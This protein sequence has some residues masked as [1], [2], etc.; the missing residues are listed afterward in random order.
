MTKKDEKNKGEAPGSSDMETSGATAESLGVD[1][2]QAKMDEEQ[3]KGYR[4]QK[5][6]PTPNANYTVAGVTSG[7]PTPETDPALAAKTGS[8]RFTHLNE[9]EDK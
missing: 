9:T 3:E 8:G 6:D 1:E 4:G 7:A 5:V 2:V